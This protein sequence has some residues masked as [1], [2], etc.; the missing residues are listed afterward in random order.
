MRETGAVAYLNKSE[1]AIALIALI[2]EH[3]VHGG[4]SM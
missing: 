2:L 3:A 4:Q 1:A